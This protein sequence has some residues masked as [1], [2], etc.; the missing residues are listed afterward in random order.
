MYVTTQELKV[1]VREL[2]TDISSVAKDLGGDIQF[3]NYRIGELQNMLETQQE[4]INK[5]KT[6]LDK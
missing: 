1:Q 6:V 5:L 2:K 3:L 4:I